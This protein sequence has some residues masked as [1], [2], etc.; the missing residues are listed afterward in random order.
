MGFRSQPAGTF[1]LRV[2]GKP[3]VEFDVALSDKAWESRDGSVRVRYTI[4]QRNDEDSNGLLEIELHP[5]RVSMGEPVLFEVR[6][7][8]SAS[9]RWFGVYSITALP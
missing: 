5:S 1:E 7:S 6:A 4:M 8:A 3:G 9:Q 2:N